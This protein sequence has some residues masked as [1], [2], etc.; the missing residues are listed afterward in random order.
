MIKRQGQF[1]NCPCK[2]YGSFMKKTAIFL[3]FSCFL[4]SRISAQ[5]EEDV[6]EKVKALFKEGVELQNSGDYRGAIEIY[7]RALKIIS[8]PGVIYN[9]ARCYE[10]LN[11][12][13]RAVEYYEKYIELYKDINKKEP[14]DY[15]KILNRIDAIKKQKEPVIMLDS[16]RKNIPGGGKYPWTAQF[17]LAPVIPVTSLKGDA[18][19]SSFNARFQLG[20]RFGKLVSHDPPLELYFNSLF[21]FQGSITWKYYDENYSFD[22]DPSIKFIYLYP[23]LMYSYELIHGIPLYVTGEL[24]TGIFIIPGGTRDLKYQGETKDQLEI[25]GT[26]TGMI[27]KPSI[28][29]KYELFDII[30]F[31]LEPLSVPVDIPITSYISDN[32]G[33]QVSFEIR[34]SIGGRF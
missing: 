25:D 34:F 33:V 14:D 8:S 23:S 32:M 11:E 12:P 30:V 4:A 17:M 5:S 28:G 1:M 18:S 3:I 29:I 7:E 20:C 2:I 6:M 31:H 16:D 21:G 13:D 24:G 9:M 22:I 10:E 19:D 27:I 26:Q 15:K